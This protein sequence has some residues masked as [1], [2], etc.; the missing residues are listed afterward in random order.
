LPSSKNDPDWRVL[1]I[2]PLYL[3]IR[4]FEDPAGRVR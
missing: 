2:L 4:R 1:I 3:S